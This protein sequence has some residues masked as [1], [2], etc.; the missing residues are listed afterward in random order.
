MSKTVLKRY[1]PL[2]ISLL[3]T[4]I[5][6]ALLFL[7]PSPALGLTVDVDA[8]KKFSGF[9]AGFKLLDPDTGQ[10]ETVIIDADANLAGGE[11]ADIDRATL[12]IVQL[13]GDAGFIDFSG[14]GSDPAV[15]LPLP[16]APDYLAIEFFDVTS[17]LPVDSTGD[18]QGLLFV[19]VQLVNVIGDDLGFG[20]GYRG[21]QGG[22]SIRFKIKYTPPQIAGTYQ[23][24][25]RLLDV[26]GAELANNTTNFVLL[27][28]LAPGSAIALTTIYPRGATEA[29][30]RDLVI[31]RADISDDVLW[32]VVSVT[33]NLGLLGSG[34]ATLDPVS[35]FHPAILA[36]WGVDPAT[37]DFL[38]P[39]KILPDVPLPEEFTCD[40]CSVPITVVDIAGQQLQLT[41][42]A[43]ATV[44]LVNKRSSFSIYLMPGV[45][46]IS[47]PL[48]CD[49]GGPL[50]T[51]DFE[52]DLEQFLSQTAVNAAAGFSTGGAVVEIIWY[53]CA[54]GS[55]ICP[56]PGVS[57]DFVSFVPGLTVN[58]LAKVGTGKGFILVAKDTAFNTLL[59]TG[60]N[61]Q[62][63]DALPV[64]IKLTFT[65]DVFADTTPFTLPGLEV[66]TVWN[67]VGLHSE[68]NSTVGAL[69]NNVQVTERLWQQ[70]FSF[71][72]SLDIL[73]DSSGKVI[74]DPLTDKP[75][76]A[77]TQGV[78]KN[79][80]SLDEEIRAGGG[81][82]LEMCDDKPECNSIIGPVQEP[83]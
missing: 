65:G 55:T 58:P 44:D 80:F 4:A 61:P 83:R 37:T 77:L 47:T 23:A 54:L 5:V 7:R 14:T 24:T 34:S 48:Q 46:F 82:W 25:L 10:P 18:T 70:L 62:L 31:V 67:L 33:A 30:S 13:S 60:D 6:L 15:L 52:F 28:Q 39:V 57:G 49:Q 21:Q 59:D 53:Y 79:L 16:V 75:L 17:G 11:V 78:F 3:I 69:V 19:D 8:V 36:K 73:L 9:D 12:D 40:G 45:Q 63:S 56:S 74:R 76:L 51:G 2:Y 29:M 50:C 35:K 42:S 66:R 41:D 38:A 72:N 81:F 27:N 43:A 22:G 32:S 1:A 64:P 68:R 71:T 20:Y 26:N